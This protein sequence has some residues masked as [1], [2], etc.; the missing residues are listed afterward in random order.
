MTSTA[1]KKS[2]PS[3]GKAN[4]SRLRRL[5]DAEINR[6]AP[7]ELLD[8]R[9]DFWENSSLVLPVAKQAISLRIDEDVLAWFKASGPGYQSRMNTVLRYYMDH[10]RKHVTRAGVVS[11]K[12][13][14]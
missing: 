13:A 11:T 8:L 5:T 1:R 10:M 4:L 6:T 14:E 12:V 3:R 9:D 7:P 2:A